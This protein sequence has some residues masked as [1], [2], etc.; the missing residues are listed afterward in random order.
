ML[1]FVPLRHPDIASRVAHGSS[2]RDRWF[3]RSGA[4]AAILDRHDQGIDSG[5][6]TPCAVM[7]NLIHMLGLAPPEKSAQFD[8]RSL[9]NRNSGA[10]TISKSN[11]FFTLLR[12]GVRPRGYMTPRQNTPSGRKGFSI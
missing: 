4:A 6:F 3:L 12:L 9:T 5:L 1:A 11:F 10:S 7:L 2:A 8:A